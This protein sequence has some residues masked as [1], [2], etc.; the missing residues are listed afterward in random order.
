MVFRAVAEWAIRRAHP[1]RAGPSSVPSPSSR[2]DKVHARGV[3]PAPAAP[4]FSVYN[5][6]INEIGDTGD[7][8]MQ[9]AIYNGINGIG[10]TRTNKTTVSR[11][12]GRRVAQSWDLAGV[13]ALMGSGAAYGVFALTHLG[14]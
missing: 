13:L 6:R 10:A 1:C 8:V 9:Q 2:C 14:F 11:R 5:R 12:I 3:T 7:T 4:R